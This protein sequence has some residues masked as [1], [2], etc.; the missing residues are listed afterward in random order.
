[1]K[2]N[3]YVA[4]SWRNSYQPA[5]VKFLRSAGHDVY[6]FR[7]PCDGNTGFSW[8][9]I[10]PE[11]QGWDISA[12]RQALQSPIAEEGYRCDIEAL[13]KADVVV[14]LL[15]SGRSAH[16]EAAYHRGR[17]GVVIVHSPERCEPELMYKMFNAF[18]IDETELVELL[19][20]DI[21]Q[22]QEGVLD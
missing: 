13:E 9:E 3:I 21:L 15:P 22:L 4:S 8:S 2:H 14:L 5:M 17:G 12:F 1:M 11:W 10:D 20:R 7:N 16:I 18:T 19:D 6:D